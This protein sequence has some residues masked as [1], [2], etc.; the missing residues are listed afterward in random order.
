MRFNSLD[1]WLA[2]QETLHPKAIDLGLARVR[3]VAA[4]MGLL[5]PRHIVI[6]VAG[7]NG[8]GSSVALLEAILACAGLRVG[9]YT[10]PHLWRYN[11][12]I[13]IDRQP[14]DD[15]AL[16]AAFDRIDTARGETSL[17]YFEFGTLAA[18]D[19]LQRAGVEVAILE[20][21]LGG[22][23]D[24]VNVL[25]ADGA[26]V[27]GIGIDHVEWLGADRESIGREKAG[28][29]RSGRA[30]V[31]SDPRPPAALREVARSLGA[32]WYGLGEQ[33]GYARA[34]D[35]WTWWGP[36]VTLHDLPLPALPGPFQLQNAAGV[37]MVLQAL[38][39]RL[40]LTVRAL[41]AGLRAAQVPGRFT[42]VPGAVETIFDVA[43][44]PHAAAALA[45][46]LAARPC[47]GRTLAVCGMLADKDA[48]GVASAL[49]GQVQC[50]YLGGLSGERGQSAQ[51]LAERMALPSTQRQVY[52]DMA[53]AYA[54]ARAAARPGDR[55]VVFGSFH[56]IAEL[57]PPGL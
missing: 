28:I 12:R 49:A 36:G 40:P 25:N 32:T 17:S 27:T 11:E 31:C 55:V 18:F 9:T 43:H 21:G 44:N 26:L 33:F 35:T 34:D 8:K 57:L 14:V 56:T 3:E 52:P 42:V 51:A 30:A 15:A 39:E 53:A 37:L 1:E 41:H 16:V 5:E 50:W 38:G 45:D 47:G 4:R 48:A 10:S 22:R 23:L 24:A 46:A 19:I 54:A 6:S 20:V 7:T 13:R 29:F 2:W